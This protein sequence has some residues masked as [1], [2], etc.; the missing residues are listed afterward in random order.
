MA[1]ATVHGYCRVTVRRWG[2]ARSNDMPNA[3]LS[4]GGVTWNISNTYCARLLKTDSSFA[5]H[6]CGGYLQPPNLQI[7]YFRTLF[8]TN[9]ANWARKV[10]WSERIARN[11]LPF[12]WRLLVA[13][14]NK[15]CDVTGRN[16]NH[17][18]TQQGMDTTIC[19]VTWVNGSGKTEGSSLKVKWHGGEG[20]PDET[21]TTGTHNKEWTLQSAKRRESTDQVQLKAV[22]SGWSGTGGEGGGGTPIYKPY[23]YVP[24][25]RV[26]F[27]S[28]SSLN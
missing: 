9:M 1:I 6:Q 24:P 13:Q 23:R 2:F 16:A 19:K 26:S 15:C 17:R 25:E 7:S 5:Q 10:K 8:T 11:I 28:I 21:P 3:A 27:W 14:T 12:I 20:A 4:G 18:N 22:L